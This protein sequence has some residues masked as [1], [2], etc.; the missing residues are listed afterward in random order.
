MSNGQ[1]LSIQSH[2]DLL[3]RDQGLAISK[4]NLAERPVTPYSSQES[5]TPSKKAKA[6]GELLP[7][8]KAKQ[9]PP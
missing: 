6:E 3:T 2:P 5:G 7:N 1:P 4:G 8:I 9:T